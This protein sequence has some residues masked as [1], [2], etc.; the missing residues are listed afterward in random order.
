MKVVLQSYNTCCQ[1]KMGGV[2]LRIRKIGELLSAKGVEVELFNP[3]VTDLSTADILHVFKLD[4]ESYETIMCAKSL[5]K[6]VVISSVIN[7]NKAL[8]LDIYMRIF[9]RMHIL[10]D[11][12]L[13]HM[14]GMKADKIIAE[15]QQEADFI[16]KHYMIPIDKILVIPNGNEPIIYNG[17]EIFDYFGRQKKYILHVG[18]IDKNKNQLNVIK[19]LKDTGIDIV[20]IGGADL[21]RGG[22]YYNQC[23]NAAKGYPNIHFLGWQNNDSPLLKSAYAHA[24]TFVLASFE[25]TFGL[26]LLEAGMAGA[27]LAVSETLPILDYPVFT[28]CNRFNPG[29]LNSIRETVLKTFNDAPDEQLRQEITTYFSWDHIIEDHINLYSELYNA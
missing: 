18:R 20:F 22:D 25:E 1:N 7:L 11:I 19:A 23:L 6:K 3:F 9:H 29:N 14:A 13:A 24:D 15:T 16:C 21:A 17:T 4:H 12:G 28:K 10:T 2:Q 8:K 5:G 26:V 27:K